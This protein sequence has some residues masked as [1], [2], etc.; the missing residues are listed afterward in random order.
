MEQRDSS[1]P[2]IL[3]FSYD[4]AG[5][6]TGSIRHVYG[7]SITNIRT[8]QD[9]TYDESGNLL[10]LKRYGDGPQ[11]ALV[12][13]LCF[14]YDGPKR[15]GWTYDPNGNVTSDPLNGVSIAWNVIDQPRTLTSGTSS[16]QRNYLADGTLASTQDGSQLRIFLGDIVF[17]VAS[18]GFGIESAGWEGGRLLPG[19]GND[20]VIYYVND[21]LGSVRTVKDGAGTVRQRYDYYPYGM[22]SR[23]WSSS[24]SSDTPDKRY[25]FGGKEIAGTPLSATATGSDKYLDFGARLYNPRSATWLSQDPLAE[26]YYP[27]GPYV[28][29]HN[30]PITR[31]DMSGM[32]DYYFDVHGNW[33][34]SYTNDEFDRLFAPN[35]SVMIVEDQSI[36]GGMVPYTYPTRWGEDTTMNE[37]LHFTVTDGSAN[38]LMDVFFFLA[39][40]TDV[41]W[42]VIE[43]ANGYSVLGTEHNSSSFR[44]R[45][46]KT[47]LEKQKNVFYSDEPIFRIHS[48]PLPYSS[49]RE[50]M[51]GD[52][53]NVL[54]NPAMSNYVY[55]PYSKHIYTITAKSKIKLWHTKK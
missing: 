28:Y 27:I 8:E 52:Y 2:E 24:S 19:A 1:Y 26:K 40:N 44:E 10:T 30:S 49:E 17:K 7:S 41:E 48:H 50:S 47:A 42:I 23:S 38:Q 6:L 53:Q 20:K 34:V 22:V 9:I 54:R 39:D 46:L 36:M 35:G 4:K 31:A 18:G 12:D 3:G 16:T 5:R 29:C 21:H 15:V 11:P 25:R 45:P 55:F 14:S 13:S 43:G 37:T 51:I 33:Q 32:N